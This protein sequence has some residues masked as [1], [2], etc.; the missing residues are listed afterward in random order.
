MKLTATLLSGVASCGHC[1]HAVVNTSFKLADG[2]RR[3]RYVC[4][5]AQDR[6]RAGG[7]PCPLGTFNAQPVDD[8][9]WARVSALL[10]DSQ[11]LAVAA[12]ISDG[13]ADIPTAEREVANLEAKLARADEQVRDTLR[14]QRRGKLTEEQ[15]DR[16][17][18]DINRERTLV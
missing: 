4:C 5:S 17:V 10:L 9:V 13:A 6:Y 16:A 3:P 15:R 7:R 18:E 12:S 1:G 14:L 2:T 11:A 8:A